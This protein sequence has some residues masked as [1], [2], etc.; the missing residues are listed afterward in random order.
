MVLEIRHRTYKANIES[1]TTKVNELTSS[2]T[3]EENGEKSVVFSVP[4][5]QLPPDDYYLKLSGTDEA[6]ETEFIDS[7]SFGIAKR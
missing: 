7:Y 5:R 1:E 3:R 2:Q 6:G 4:T